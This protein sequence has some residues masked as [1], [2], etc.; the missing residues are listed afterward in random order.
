MNKLFTTLEGEVTQVYI[1]AWAF[2]ST[3][4]VFA[5]LYV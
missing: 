5:L 4:T 2:F 1:I 3:L